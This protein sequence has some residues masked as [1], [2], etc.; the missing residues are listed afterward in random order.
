[1]EIFDADEKGFVYF[2]LFLEASS[3]KATTQVFILL[4]SMLM[5]KSHEESLYH[6]SLAR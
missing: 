3:I 6:E 1:M 5:L 4:P 2:I